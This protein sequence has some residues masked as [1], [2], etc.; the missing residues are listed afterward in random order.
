MGPEEAQPP[1]SGVRIAVDVG[2][3][4]VGVAASDAGGILAS[5]VATLARDA[6]RGT[7]LDAVAGLVTERE[8]VEVLVGLPRHLSGREGSSV[9]MARRY[10]TQL[11]ARIAPVPVRMVDERLT[12]VS[13]ERD[14]AAAGMSARQRR[15]VVDQAA[16]VVLLQAELEALRRR[17]ATDDG[18]AG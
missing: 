12:T 14:L 2:T 10:A 9:T 18:G 5:P 3:V 4:R 6:K 16:A 11:A 15:A 1:R 13:A 7:D 17:G 8:A